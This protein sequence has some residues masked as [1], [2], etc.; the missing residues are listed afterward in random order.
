MADH[1]ALPVPLLRAVDRVPPEIWLVVAKAVI[2]ED[3]LHTTVPA[4][5]TKCLTT[6]PTDFP[7]LRAL[8]AALHDLHSLVLTKKTIHGSALTCLYEV[9]LIETDNAARTLHHT[10]VENPSLSYL[11]QYTRHLIL[12]ALIPAA[13]PYIPPIIRAMS[14][15][16]IFSVD[17]ISLLNGDWP[18]EIAVALG[19]TCGP[20][21]RRIDLGYQANHFITGKGLKNLLS[22]TPRLHTLIV[23]DPALSSKQEFPRLDDLSCLIAEA[24]IIVPF[25]EAGSLAPPFP[26]LVHLH[27]QAVRWTH[28]P[29]DFLR[30]QGPHL[31]SI[32]F[33]LTAQWGAAIR[34]RIKRL[35]PLFPS[36]THAQVILKWLQAA[37]ISALPP[38][39][40]HLSIWWDPPPPVFEE[41][42]ATQSWVLSFISDLLELCSSPSADV[43]TGDLVCRPR[44]VRL[45]N[46]AHALWLR[47]YL[48]RADTVFNFPPTSS[49]LRVEGPAG[50]SF[51]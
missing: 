35:W 31:S 46:P 8:K 14:S 10:L 26:S 30:R 27:I 43:V 17:P 3:F 32:T 42:A 49:A 5:F 12:T 18:E 15:I 7:N 16:S 48:D 38:T 29:S 28:D 37:S 13:F 36:V 51:P 1:K 45:A 39:V 34:M 50:E 47:R 24:G 2:P 21:L 40:T 4:P 44:I 25:L 33:D 41:D 6:L 19:E 9:V 11:A 23:R 22:S 20:S